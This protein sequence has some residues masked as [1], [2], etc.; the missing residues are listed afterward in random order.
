MQSS[1]SDLLEQLAD[2]TGCAYLSDLRAL[3]SFSKK[4]RQ[5]LNAIPV[6]NFSDHQWQEALDYLTGIHLDADG[7]TCRQQLLAYLTQSNSCQKASSYP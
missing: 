7:P 3:P 1:S 2:L 5:A 6:Q 4:L